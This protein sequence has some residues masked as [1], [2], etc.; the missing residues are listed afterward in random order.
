[1]PHFFKYNQGIE[2]GIFQSRNEIVQGGPISIYSL[3]VTIVQIL[4]QP[5]CYH[6]MG[7]IISAE[8]D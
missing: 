2:K 3:F 7:V 1:M 4:L 6:R 5:D 8:K